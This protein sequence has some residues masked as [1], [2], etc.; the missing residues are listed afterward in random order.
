[1]KLSDFFKPKP[2]PTPP[3]HQIDLSDI[4]AQLLV[5]NVKLGQIMSILDQLT[6]D[7]S[8]N[9]SVVQSAVVLING[10][11]QQLNDA[12]AALQ[13][14]DNGAALTKLSADLE[15][16]TQALADAVH[17]NTGTAPPATP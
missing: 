11:H 1:M 5:I 12:I 13:A 4:N 10:L 6:Q 2:P 7:V 8:N 16:S 9:T 17:A 14:G 3:Q 15:A